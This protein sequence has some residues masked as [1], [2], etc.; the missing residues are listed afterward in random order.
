MAR[1]TSSRVFLVGVMAWSELFLCF[2]TAANGSCHSRASTSCR[3]VGTNFMRSE[4]VGRAL[5]SGTFLTRMPPASSTTITMGKRVAKPVSGFV[6][7]VVAHTVRGSSTSSVCDCGSRSSYR[8]AGCGKTRCMH[9]TQNESSLRCRC[10]N[11]LRMLKKAVQQGRSERR[12]EA[13]ARYVEPLSDARTP[14]ADFFSFLLEHVLSPGRPFSFGLLD[15]L[16]VRL[17][18]PQV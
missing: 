12:G 5:S 8:L 2:S 14:L 15:E 7:L 6:A 16:H 10:Q 1:K 11:R 3:L 13:Y 18:R 4:S 9:K 17:R